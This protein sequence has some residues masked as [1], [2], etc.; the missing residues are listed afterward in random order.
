MVE[1]FTTFWIDQT[2]ELIA[3]D[4]D[5]T[6]S[7]TTE[8]TEGP[9]STQP[10]VTDPPTTLDPALDS[11]YDGCGETKTCFGIGSENCFE[12]RVCDTVG[13]VIANDGRYF[14]EM[15]SPG[16][17]TL[18]QFLW[19]PSECIHPKLVPATLH[20]PCHKTV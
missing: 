12:N 6:T 2:S 10:P 20:L 15:R 11:F 5:A 17:N 16:K 19:K 18:I 9:S 7:E 4:V 1:N 14:F 8:S 3:V 13:A